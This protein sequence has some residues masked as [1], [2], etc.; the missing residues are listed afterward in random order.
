MWRYVRH[1]PVRH[2]VIFLSVVFAVACTVI[3]SYATRYLVDTLTAHAHGPMGPVWH[4]V[5][6]LA[7]LIACDNM[8]WR[9]GG[10]YAS[11]AFVE[12]T[13]DLRRDLFRYL[14]AH[15]APYFSDRMPGAL[16]A[17]IGTAATASF[18]LES[19]ATWNVLPPCLNVALSITLL[20]TV[21]PVMAVVIVVLA[22]ALALLMF[23]M[24]ESGRSHHQLFASEAAT[25][26]AEMLDV[27]S[28]MPLVR[29]FGMVG[30]ERE[31][32][33][34]VIEREMGARGRSLRYLEKLRLVHAVLTALLTAGLLIWVVLLWHSGA[35]SIGDVVMVITL[36][37]MIL[38]GTRDLAVALVET[39][40]HTAR[41]EEALSAL[42]VP[43]DMKDDPHALT[44]EAHPRGEIIFDDVTFAY[45]GGETPV[46]DHFNL[47][48]RA[49]TRVGLVGRSGSGKSTVIG[50]LQR[51]RFVQG[52]AILVDGLD[53][54]R[55]TEESLRASMSVVPQDVTMLR[56]SVL[57]NIRYG[58]PEASEDEVIAAATA[59]GCL[60][61]IEAMP[62][63]FATEVGDRG[64]KLSGGQ[65]QRIAIA[66]AFL[67]NAPILILDEATSALDSESEQHV[68]AALDRLMMGRT[69][70]AVAHRLST[71]KTFDRIVVMQY[72]RIVQ[73]DSP[74]MLERMDGP[75]RDLLSRQAMS[76]DDV[77]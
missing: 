24:A 34:G 6:L 13:G 75:Y 64:V 25:V 46:L 72:G 59:A 61:F 17:R 11:H 38:H 30:R 51:M 73:D 69:V 32:L 26:D 77:I 45:P 9:V 43:H 60:D 23:R 33:A 68:Q 66:R 57:E 67:R 55:L 3:G 58:K 47:H 8:S 31:R 62:E 19:L 40:Q 5:T 35:A 71:L 63:G 7:V 44:F 15:S 74:Q 4:A 16:A 53:T 49:G 56:R 41:L 12:V 48:I 20:A 14:T 65:R 10:W 2:G 28:S 29:S 70:I 27:V 22:A 39:I 21:S 42:L 18:T 50:L 52:G 37:F 1:H 54:R 36:G 76:L